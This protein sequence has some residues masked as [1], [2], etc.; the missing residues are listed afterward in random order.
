[1][2]TLEQTEFTCYSLTSEEYTNAATFTPMNKLLLHNMLS[3]TANSILQ[4][5][6]SEEFVANSLTQHKYLTGKLDI[7]RELLAFG[8]SDAI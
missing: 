5:D 4:L 8:T 7:L 3:E 6:F 2:A 1:M